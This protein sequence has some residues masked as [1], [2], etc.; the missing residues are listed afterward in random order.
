MVD[1]APCMPAPACSTALGS[2]AVIL[3]SGPV[4]CTGFPGTGFPAHAASVS[5]HTTASTAGRRRE[6]AKLSADAETGRPRPRWRTMVLEERA[7]F[8]RTYDAV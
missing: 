2:P 4:P 1:L 3:V 7:Q 5:E 8:C 6:C